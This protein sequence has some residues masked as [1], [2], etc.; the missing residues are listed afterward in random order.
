MRV[1]IGGQPVVRVLKVVPAGLVPITSVLPVQ[2]GAEGGAV[3]SIGQA[4]TESTRLQPL[5]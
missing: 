2:A 5:M 3:R 4:D 1:P